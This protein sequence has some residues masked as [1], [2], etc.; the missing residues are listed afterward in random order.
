MD[1]GAWRAADRSV[2]RRRHD[3]SAL[4]RT[5]VRLWPVYIFVLGTEVH[6]LI[7]KKIRVDL[8]LCAEHTLDV[9]TSQGG[10]Q[11]WNRGGGAGEGAESGA[12]GP[13][14]NA[15]E[16]GGAVSHPAS[17][18]PEPSPLSLQA[19]CYPAFPVS[20]RRFCQTRASASPAS[21][22]LPPLVPSQSAGGEGKWLAHH[23]PL[24]GA[25][26][27]SP[28]FSETPPAPL[29]AAAPTAALYQ[30]RTRGSP[31]TLGPPRSV[32]VSVG[33]PNQ[34]RPQ[35]VSVTFSAEKRGGLR[36]LGDAGKHTFPVGF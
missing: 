33:K 9:L 22:S 6:T 15:E 32:P 2:A 7:K 16:Q 34:G 18:S 10:A 1:G 11:W 20:F 27:P 35:S 24:P 3:R 30:L 23:T 12:D 25:P 17:G 5:H 14:R 28:S 36:L 21:A 29:A 26:P 8:A 31:A 4:A 19:P 13:R